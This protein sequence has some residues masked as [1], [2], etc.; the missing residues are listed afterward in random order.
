[1]L[2]DVIAAVAT[3]PGRSALAV[4]RI[5]GRDAFAVAERV[6]APFAA[7]PPRAARL[8]HARSP[9]DGEPIDQVV[10][11]T[12][13]GPDSYTGEDAVEITTHGGLSAPVD[14]LMALLAAGAREASPGEFTRR[15]VMNGKMDLL[16]AEAVGDLIEATAPAQRRAAISQLDRHLSGRIEALRTQIVE[17]E[18]LVAYEID[19]PEEDS[20]PV[21]PERVATAVA[22][23]EADLARLVAGSGDGERLREGALVVIAGPPNAGK[24][25][26]F[27]ALVGRERAIV[28]EVPGTT[29]D[30]IEAPISCRGFPFR[31]V[32]TAG[33]RDADDRVERLGVDVSRQYVRDADIVLLCA[34]I[35]APA[36]AN[37]RSALE[38]IDA[39]VVEV[40]TKADLGS[41]DATGLPTSAVTGEGLPE[42]R[43]ALAQ[44]AFRSLVD[45]GDVEPMITRAR[46]R[47]SV[48]NALEEVRAFAKARESGLETAVAAVH[49]RTAVHALED[50][51]GLVTTDDVLDRLFSSFCVGK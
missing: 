20:G 8:A 16:Q 37:E 50:V 35:D 25:S 41:A 23:V 4:L 45:R 22:T 6:L 36:S 13:R 40:T 33:L 3:P 44:A 30:A 32:D 2:T 29:R 15:A 51:I 19:F 12:Y 38:Q 28:T 46:H 24:S 14:T 31:L 39:L 10:Y 43:D 5:S 48:E 21:P 17:L 47:I 1:M 27:N 42:L 11:L 26:L 49:L 7:D 18:A 9:N 34:P